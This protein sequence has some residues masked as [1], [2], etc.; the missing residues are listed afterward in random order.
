MITGT[1]DEL[2]AYSHHFKWWRE[3]KEQQLA[4]RV[5]RDAVRA[6]S[7]PVQV[8]LADESKEPPKPLA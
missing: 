6:A 8:G 4:R 1:V 7:H 3:E 2:Y 5:Q